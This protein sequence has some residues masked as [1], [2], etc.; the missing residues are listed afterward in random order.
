MVAE[1]KTVLMSQILDTL[2]TVTVTSPRSLFLTRWSLR[3]LFLNIPVSTDW[4]DISLIPDVPT[5]SELVPELNL[6]LWNGL[7]VHITSVLN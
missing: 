1:K 4:I 2:L 7:F 6:V 5:V 3:S